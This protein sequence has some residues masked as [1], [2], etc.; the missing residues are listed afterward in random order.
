VIAGFTVFVLSFAILS[1][2]G[3]HPRNRPDRRRLLSTRKLRLFISLGAAVIAVL[4]ITR[5]N[6]KRLP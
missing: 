3:I 6:S 4:W 2:T 5:G 1:G